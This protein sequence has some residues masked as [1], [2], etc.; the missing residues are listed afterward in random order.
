MAKSQETRLI[1]RVIARGGKFLGDDIGGAH[2]T[3]RD[4]ISGEILAAGRTHGA[5]GPTTVMSQP[6]LRTQPIPTL[7]TTVKPPAEACNFDVKLQL[8]EP[9]LLEI[10][11]YGPLAAPQ[12]AHTVTTT[13]WIY[14]GLSQTVGDGL[15]LEI[16]GLLVQILNPPTHFLPAQLSP[17]LI[18]IQANVTMM[19]GCPV[20]PNNFWPPTQFQVTATIRTNGAVVD[21]FPLAFDSAV[22]YPSQFIG[23]WKAPGAGIYELTV[24]A[25]QTTSGNTGVN[26]ATFI[27][28]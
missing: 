1:I 6:L 16:P 14:P 7:D 11:A 2:I 13:H 20:T 26:T 10:T 25:Y 12:G 15:V 18:N 17:P 21:E 28:P 24:V 9:K 27:V 22:N 23:S 4:S 3:V 8:S 19:C 5:S